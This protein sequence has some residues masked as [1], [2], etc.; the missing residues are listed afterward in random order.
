MVRLVMTEFLP[1]QGLM[2]RNYPI[3]ILPKEIMP[4]LYRAALPQIAVVDEHDNIIIRRK[5]SLNERWRNK[6]IEGLIK[7]YGL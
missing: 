6:Q 7:Q 3:T 5:L 1:D 4:L 2:I